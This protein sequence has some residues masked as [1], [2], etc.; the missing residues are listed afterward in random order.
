M[1]LSDYVLDFLEKKGVSKVF[2]ENMEVK[3]IKR[4]KKVFEAN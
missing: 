4:N 3:S 2:F 1:N